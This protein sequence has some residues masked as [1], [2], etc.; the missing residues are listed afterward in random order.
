MKFLFDTTYGLYFFGNNQ[1]MLIYIQ[2]LA[3]YVDILN[4]SG[5]VRHYQ[6]GF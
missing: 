3:F 4:V 1:L 5:G 6:T 2:K